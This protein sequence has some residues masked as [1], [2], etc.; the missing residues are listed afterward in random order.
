MP[1][2]SKSLSHL[3]VRNWIEP[4]FFLH[5]K[6]FLFGHDLVLL[7]GLCLSWIGPF[8]LILVCCHELAISSMRPMNNDENMKI[9]WTMEPTSLLTK[10]IRE[11][12]NNP[13]E[14]GWK[15]PD[16]PFLSCYTRH[17]YFGANKKV[18]MNLILLG[19]KNN[20]F[21]LDIPEILLRE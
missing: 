11:A 9:R 18:P 5:S 10:T 20:Q 2:R 13:N 21:I 17:H 8:L 4:W 7:F 15:K 14:L 19:I 12:K 16:W 6:V 3:Q 1:I